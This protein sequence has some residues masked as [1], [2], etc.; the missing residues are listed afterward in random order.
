V[1]YAVAP[2]SQFIQTKPGGF[3]PASRQTAHVGNTAF[4]PARYPTSPQ[5][6]RRM[7]P[8]SGCA[9][10]TSVGSECPQLA[11]TV[12]RV[13]FPSA[14]LP[15]PLLGTPP[16]SISNQARSTVCGHDWNLLAE[17][18]PYTRGRGGTPLHGRA[19]GS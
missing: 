15:L 14:R 5:V 7:L 6:S 3:H 1:P 10:P 18:A 19:A 4:C 11:Q 17:S 16:P 12:R 13:W 8:S 2:A 9:W